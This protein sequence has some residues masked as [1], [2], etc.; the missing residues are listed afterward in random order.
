MP[1]PYL[2]VDLFL[3]DTNTLQIIYKNTLI[4]EMY[5]T[6]RS[7]QNNSFN[8]DEYYGTLW[9]KKNIYECINV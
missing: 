1:N 7:E 2:S 4:F 5:K 8:G 9:N 3:R 6:Y